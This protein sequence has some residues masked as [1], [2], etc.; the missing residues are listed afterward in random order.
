MKLFN[1]LRAER[2]AGDFRACYF[3]IRKPER[4]T[5]WLSI[6]TIK[7]ISIMIGISWIMY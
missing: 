2:F 4:K 3:K 7:A 6:I 5:L 1:P